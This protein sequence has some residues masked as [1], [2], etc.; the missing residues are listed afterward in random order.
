[1]RVFMPAKSAA[2]V[3]FALNV[4][5]AFGIVERTAYT[6]HRRALRRQQ[7][8]GRERRLVVVGV[9]PR[10]DRFFRLAHASLSSRC[11]RS[12]LVRIRFRLSARSAWD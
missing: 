3:P 12:Y 11:F 5:K 4:C 7:G 2:T 6:V 1:M 9:V 8:A 10:Q